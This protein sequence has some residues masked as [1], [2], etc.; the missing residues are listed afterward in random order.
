M[1]ES[2][3]DVVDRLRSTSLSARV[4][5]LVVGLLLLAL[6]ITSLTAA[7]FMERHLVRQ[8]DAELRAAAPT[9][10][11]AALRHDHDDPATRQLPSL[12][13]AGV[14]A[15]RVEHSTGSHTDVFGDTL[16]PDQLP[17]VRAE[18][19][20]GPFTATADRDGARWRVLRGEHREPGGRPTPYWIAVS[21]E[22]VDRT[23]DRVLVVSLTSGI[24]VVLL[25]AGLG[26]IGV[27]HVMRPLTDI[28]DT[29]ATIAAGDL[30]RRVD[31]ATGTTEVN[32]LARS[33]NRMLERIEEAFGVRERSEER[34]RQ[35]VADAS[36]E[37]RT[38]LATIRGYA[39]LYRAGALQ[40]P[41]AIGSATGRIESEATRMAG[42]VDSL[43]LLNRL[44]ENRKRPVEE[45]RFGEVDLT[46]LAADAVED[47]RVR[48]R[49]RSIRLV[50]AADGLG[51]TPVRGDDMQ[52]RQVLT[53]LLT[54][55]LRYSPDGSPIEVAVGRDD[56][57]G[58]FEVR[59]HGEGI[60]DDLREKVF[61]R[62]YRAEA[63]RNSDLGGSGLGL[64][65]VAAIVA[66]HEGNVG[67]ET[68][69]GGGAT[70][71]VRLPLSDES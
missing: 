14:Y 2:E 27:R 4:T 31:E 18:D 47:A 46:V 7:L 3:S 56:T 37:L 67:V 54:N 40:T 49:E 30:T 55:A 57:H 65:I 19:G 21:L 59:D 28:E 16:S 1:S 24:V 36:H 69:E 68:T 8:Q 15:V 34:M 66:A 61:E 71:V 63:S 64:S 20:R 26:W 62:F 29:A 58:W 44:D 9:L 10:V 5:A 41:E 12:V 70:F 32:S 60:P 13:T 25:A 38:P 17:T 52:L 22:R 23:V 53:N 6:F 43:L 39:E 50:S 35:F 11:R 48:E 45:R 51:P 33:L 42:L